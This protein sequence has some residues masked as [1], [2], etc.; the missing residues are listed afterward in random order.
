LRPATSEEIL[1]AARSILSRTVRRGVSLESPRAVRDYLSVTL[2]NRPYEIFGVIYVDN[3]HRLIEWQELFRGTL[4]G[5]SV[6]PREVVREALARNAAACILVH[7]H[8]SGDPTPSPEDVALTARLRAAGELV[9][10]RV[11]DHVVIGNG[12]FASFVDNGQL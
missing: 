6:Y 12:R 1:S 5:A 3:R 9:G 7:N 11:V 2:G 8:P 4:D 10:V